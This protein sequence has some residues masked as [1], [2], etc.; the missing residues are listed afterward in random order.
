MGAQLIAQK[1]FMNIIGRI[2]LPKSADITELYVQCNEAALIDDQ[3]DRK[4]V[5]LHQR[6]TVSSSSYFNSFYERYYVKYTSLRSIYYRLKLEG[7]FKVSVYREGNEGNERERILEE[8]FENCQL[9]IPVQLP[10][11]NLIQN[12]QAGRI[13]AEITCLSQQGVFEAG[14][15]ATDQPRKREVSLGIVI[16]TFKKESYVRNTLATLLQDELLQ[17]KTSKYLFLTTVE[18]WIR[19]SLETQE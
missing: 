5:I 4:R 3:I 15:I 19:M 18:R 17:E 1:D 13:Y 7:D 16:C 14:W 10:R 8:Q 12:Q 2:K 9:S 11:I 6:G